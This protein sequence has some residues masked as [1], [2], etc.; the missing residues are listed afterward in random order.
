MHRAH[1]EALRP[2]QQPSGMFPQVLDAPGS[3]QEFTATCMFGYAAARGLRRG[4]LD[5]SFLEPVRLAWQGAA[6]RIDDEGRVVDACAS[7]DAQ[8][9]VME[10]LDR[11]AVSGFDDRSGGMALWFAVELERLAQDDS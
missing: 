2:L 7:T 1:L 8:A 3:Y 5:L 6:Q 10:Y 4:W 11:P 9:S